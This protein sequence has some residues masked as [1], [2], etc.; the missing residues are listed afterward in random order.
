MSHPDFEDQ[1]DKMFNVTR[2]ISFDL[3][4]IRAPDV[5]DRSRSLSHTYIDVFSAKW[6]PTFEHLALSAFVIDL[7]RKSRRRLHRG[8][9][10]GR[11][12]GNGRKLDGGGERREGEE[13]R[14]DIPKSTRE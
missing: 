6:I 3:H 8:G 5:T 4:A 13:E 1:R 10:G 2:H 11:G 12:P 9:R 14:P 7:L